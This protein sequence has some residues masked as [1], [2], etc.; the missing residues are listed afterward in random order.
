MPFN[1]VIS[2][3]HVQLHVSLFPFLHICM[4]IR[5]VSVSLLKQV[6]ISLLLQLVSNDMFPIYFLIVYCTT[7]TIFY[8][9]ISFFSLAMHCSRLPNDVLIQ[10]FRSPATPL[11]ASTTEVFS[12]FI[13]YCL[14]FY[15]IILHISSP[16]QFASKLHRTLSRLRPGIWE[17][18]YSRWMI[19][20]QWSEC[21]D[22]PLTTQYEGKWWHHFGVA[23]A[24]FLECKY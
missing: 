10:C 3:S 14:A 2:L 12:S 15:I 22:S 19:T 13:S 1:P 23:T 9:F 16:S 11:S 21:R 17:S 20:R 18:S 5:G 4:E 7:A 6:Y 24:A 8:F